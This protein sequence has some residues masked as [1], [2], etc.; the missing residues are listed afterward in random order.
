MIAGPG[1]SFAAAARRLG[2]QTA[3]RSVPALPRI[4]TDSETHPGWHTLGFSSSLQGAQVRIW[5][6]EASQYVPTSLST[7]TLARRRF[8]LPVL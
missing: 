2:A 6:P 8:K 7:S 1:F 4:L 3:H 5:L